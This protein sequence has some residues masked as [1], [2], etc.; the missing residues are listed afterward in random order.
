MGRKNTGPRSTGGKTRREQRRD[1]VEQFGALRSARGCSC[2]GWSG[3]S[4]PRAVVIQGA[5]TRPDNHLA[6][7]GTG[8]EPPGDTGGGGTGAE[9]RPP[10]VCRSFQQT[11]T[12]QE[13]RRSRSPGFVPDRD[14]QADML[15]QAG[16]KLKSDIQGMQDNITTAAEFIDKTLE[17]LEEMVQKFSGTQSTHR[18]CRAG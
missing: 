3:C 2:G 13:R 18:A 6:A 4:C 15:A 17:A 1:I 14:S 8:N 12:G 10:T 7:Q 11:S 9:T 16:N 5:E